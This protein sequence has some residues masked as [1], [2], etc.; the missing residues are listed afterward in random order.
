MPPPFI[1]TGFPRSRTAWLARLLDCVHEPSLRW[2]AIDDLEHFLV[3]GAGASDC[4]MSFLVHDAVS[5]RP[6]TSI[7]LVR[8]ER[9]AVERSLHALGVTV[10]AWLLDC[11]E[12]RLD[13]IEKELK[14]LVV[15]Y[16]D[17]E[18]ETTCSR[19]HSWCR[20]RQMDRAHWQALRY[21]NIQ[22]DITKTLALLVKRDAALGALFGPRYRL[23]TTGS[24]T[25]STLKALA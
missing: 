17:L 8:R 10:A 2:S 12:R 22:A 1:V 23:W 11:M 21:Q 4:M 9:R 18:N 19:I 3:D 25:V 14:P 13:T 7:V 24:P 5:L 15:R 16:D 20:G 6:D